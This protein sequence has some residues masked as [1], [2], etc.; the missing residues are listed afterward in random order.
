MVFDSY[1]IQDSIINTT[2]PAAVLF[3]DKQHRRGERV[4][5]MADHVG[6]QHDGYLTFEL[7]LL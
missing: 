6:L 7:I 2:T 5:A 4:V 1:D 3:F